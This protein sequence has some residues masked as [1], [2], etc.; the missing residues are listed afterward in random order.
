[1]SKPARPVH[2]AMDQFP[3]VD[4]CLVVGGTPLPELARR[5]GRTPFYAYDRRLV[6]ERVELLRS[7][8]PRR[9]HI[10][11]A[12]KANPMPA[13]VAHIARRVD[14]I[15]VRRLHVH[16]AAVGG[17]APEQRIFAARGGQLHAHGADLAALRI[18]HH[19][20]ARRPSDHLVA[21]ADAEDRRAALPDPEQLLRDVAEGRA[22]LAP[23]GAGESVRS[24]WL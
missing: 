7:H 18:A 19:L 14:G 23:A 22:G 4:D 21:E 13:L 6:S 11:Y 10:H 8:L 9:V 3:V 16:Q 24:S 15:D 2:A 5:V 12:M 17:P 20:R 1:M